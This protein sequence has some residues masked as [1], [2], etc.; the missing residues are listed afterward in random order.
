MASENFPNFYNIMMEPY[1]RV[2]NGDPRHYNIYVPYTHYVSCTK[3]YVY[4]YIYI[5]REILTSRSLRASHRDAYKS[6]PDP[7]LVAVR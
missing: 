3:V 6:L 1:T 7:N 4:V 5:E 2:L